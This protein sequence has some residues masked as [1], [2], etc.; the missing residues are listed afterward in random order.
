MPL[1]R[2]ALRGRKTWSDPRSCAP[3]PAVQWRPARSGLEVGSSI[4]YPRVK[5]IFRF[6]VVRCVAV[7]LLLRS[8]GRSS[9]L[10]GPI[11][12]GWPRER[13]G[14]SEGMRAHD[15]PTA[16]CAVVAPN[17]PRLPLRVNSLAT[18]KGGVFRPSGWVTMNS[19]LLRRACRKRRSVR[20]QS[21]LVGRA[22]R[23][24]PRRAGRPGATAGS[25]CRWP[26]LDRVVRAL[27][28][29]PHRRSSRSESRAPS[30]RSGA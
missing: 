9:F 28:R 4:W 1:R 13:T 19:F 10:C 11:R 3:S 2:P 8:Y 25:S 22:A 16:G 7:C 29:A 12:G 14:H 30:L 20:P 23:S 18:S 15:A 17:R 24:S 6:V 5:A 26:A 21:F 27:W